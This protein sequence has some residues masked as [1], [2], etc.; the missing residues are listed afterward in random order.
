MASETKKPQIKP[1]LASFENQRSVYDVI[2]VCEFSAPIP[3]VCY[4]IFFSGSKVCS[5][6]SSGQLVFRAPIN[7]LVT[8]PCVW[9][10]SIFGNESCIYLEPLL[11][12]FLPLSQERRS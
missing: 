12:F 10:L 4:S 6:H 9:P 1:N 2:F 8:Y 7:A 5:E 3:I 11:F